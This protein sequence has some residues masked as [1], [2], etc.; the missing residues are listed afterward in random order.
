MNL[1]E[2]TLVPLK[3]KAILDDGAKVVFVSQDQ[4]FNF[5]VVAKG[6]TEDSDDVG[7]LLFMDYEGF[8]G[9]R[10]IKKIIPRWEPAVNDIVKIHGV[11]V[12]PGTHGRSLDYV[13]ISR[14]QEAK[15][16]GIV[17]RDFYKVDWN[18]RETIVHRDQMRLGH[19][20]EAGRPQ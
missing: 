17:E 16:L 11:A 3:T 12:I 8:S 18:G 10:T 7:S 19:R 6:D 1:G 20:P 13:R 4:E 9:A 5:V 14:P 2:M 15:I